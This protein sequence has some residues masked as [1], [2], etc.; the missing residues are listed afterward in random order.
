MLY[1]PELGRSSTNSSN[2]L[3]R[4]YMYPMY[5]NNDQ[6]SDLYSDSVNDDNTKNN[7]DF[8]DIIIQE[9][10]YFL[11]IINDDLIKD[12]DDLADV[13]NDDLI[14]DN[15]DSADV[16]NDDLIKDNDDIADYQ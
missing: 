13:I 15:Y 1:L 3:H 11:D 7:Y 8:E 2:V 6:D 16:I 14:K 12:N 10:Q 4:P 5:N 9:Y